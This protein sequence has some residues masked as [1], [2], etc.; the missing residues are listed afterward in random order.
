MESL[1]SSLREIPSGSHAT[2]PTH[3]RGEPE[4]QN[5]R[6]S[7]PIAS[8]Q[9][10]IGDIQETLTAS[11]MTKIRKRK[12]GPSLAPKKMQKKATQPRHSHRLKRKGVMRGS[13]K[14]QED[15]ITMTM[16]DSDSQEIFL[17]MYIHLL[18][19]NGIF[20]PPLNLT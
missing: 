12:G 19:Q 7:P 2:S 3:S 6:R 9:P 4:E 18:K 15:K 11:K 17:R 13:V 20:Q 1:V 14:K 8:K 10:I 16:E 5:L